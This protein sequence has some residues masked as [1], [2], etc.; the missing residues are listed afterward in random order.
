MSTS[1]ILF[2]DDEQRILDGLRRSLRAKRGEWEMSFATGGEAALELLAQSPYDVVV[3]DMRMP[4]MDGAELL[5]QISER[6]PG[7][8]R[9]VL[10]GHTEP[11]AAI[12]V[13]IAGHRFLTKPTE[14]ETLVGVIEQLIVHTSR[15]HGVQARRIAGSARALPAL[16]AQID[17]LGQLFRSAE[18]DLSQLVGAV[19]HDIGLTA[20]LLQ[21]SNSAFF[22]GRPKNASVAAVVNAIGVTTVQALVAASHSR[23]S[24][25]TW[26][27]AT[28]RYVRASWRHAVATALLVETVA[29]PAHRPHAQAAALLQDIG[30]L[31][32]I[33][34]GPSAMHEVDL[35]ADGHQGTP[36]H[37]VGVELLHL[38]G[39]SAPIVSAV[40]E[41]DQPHRAPDSGLGVSGAVRTAHLLIQ[42]TDSAD[43]SDGTHSEELSALLAHPQLVAQRVDW[44]R[45][46][47]QACT[48]AGQ[49]ADIC[50]G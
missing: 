20:K 21:L 23:W 6:H 12:K 32:C 33:G 45:A 18:L 19:M 16:P 28:E 11:D 38:W 13:A 14:T 42:Q 24:G 25:A 46:A 9:V 29:S 7:V 31:A 40:A 4:G 49:Q 15:S 1:N 8:A 3:S 5:T 44:A 35:A 39:L 43:P 34:G 10:S 37:E 36:F 41:R 26:Q 30:R 47:E 48:R 50:V 27:P 22:G 17:Q 2:V